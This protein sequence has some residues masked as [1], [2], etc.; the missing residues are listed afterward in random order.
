MK[1]LKLGLGESHDVEG[2]KDPGTAHVLLSIWVLLKRNAEL[3]GQA[4]QMML[5][6]AW[7]AGALVFN[8]P[9]TMNTA[10]V[11]ESPLQR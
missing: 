3:L 10:S 1:T 6:L 7:S 5:A 9:F 4:W 8:T 2:Q 11:A